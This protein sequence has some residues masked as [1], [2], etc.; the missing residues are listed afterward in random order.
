MKLLLPYFRGHSYEVLAFKA[1]DPMRE[2]HMRQ[3]E[4]IR[5]ATPGKPQVSMCNRYLDEGIF[6]GKSREDVIDD[7]EEAL[8]L[9]R[10]L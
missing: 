1:I 10:D 7:Q 5:R 3:N 6:H 8:N 9:E 4:S 2:M